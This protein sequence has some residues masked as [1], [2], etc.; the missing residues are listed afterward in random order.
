MHQLSTKKIFMYFS[1]ALTL[2][3]FTFLLIA[4]NSGIL[5][6]LYD[7]KTSGLYYIIVYVLLAAVTYAIDTQTKKEPALLTLFCLPIY[8]AI[9]LVI[10]LFIT[11]A[12]LLYFGLL[13]ALVGIVIGLGY[14][15]YKKWIHKI[16]LIKNGY[17][18][19]LLV[20]VIIHMFVVLLIAFKMIGLL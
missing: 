13:L 5:S 8:S 7:V 9:F 3:Y 20:Y 17:K 14:L 2:A 18:N 16:L 15:C 1:L 6:T 19:I 11:G 4:Y 12:N 10:L